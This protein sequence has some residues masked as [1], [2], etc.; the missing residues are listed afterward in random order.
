M[1]N[2]GRSI[3]SNIEIRSI[4]RVSNPGFRYSVR[5]TGESKISNNPQVPELQELTNAILA[6]KEKPERVG[7]EPTV[8]QALHSLSK[9]AP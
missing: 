5:A 2:K 1:T 9:A 3:P 6:K 8:E 7:F 4:K